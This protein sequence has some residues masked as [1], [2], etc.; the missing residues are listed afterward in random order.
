MSLDPGA[1]GRLPAAA[2]RPVPRHR[3]R[4]GRAVVL[5]LARDP[6]ATGVGVEL[7]PRLAALAAR[8]RDG[9]G[10]QPRLE[11]VVGDVRARGRLPGRRDV[12]FGRHESA[13]PDV[14]GQPP[15]TRRRTRRSRTR[16]LRSRCRSGWRARRGRCV[17]GG[18]VAAIFPAERVADLLGR[19]KP[20]ISSVPAC[21]PVHPHADAAGVAGPRRGGARRPQAAGHRTAARPSRRGRAL[22][23]GGLP[24]LPVRTKQRRCKIAAM[25]LICWRVRDW[26]ARAAAAVAAEARRARSGTAGSAW[27][28]QFQRHRRGRRAPAASSSDRRAAA[29]FTP[30]DVWNAD[31]SGRAVDAIN[32]AERMN[33]LLGSGEHP[34]RLRPRLRHPDQRGAREPGRGPDRRSTNTRTRAIR[35]HTRFPVPADPSSREPAIPTNC[36]G[37]CH[38]IVVQQGTCQVVRRLR[39]PLRAAAAGFAA[40]APTGIPPRTARA[41]VPT[42]GRPSMPPGSPSTRVSRATKRRWPAR[43]RTRCASRCRAPT[44]RASRPRPTRLSRRLPRHQPAADGPAH[45]SQGEL[46]HQRLHADGADLPARVQ[47]ARPHPRRQRREL[48]ARSTSRARTTRAGPTTSTT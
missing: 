43:S 8:G 26:A 41:S 38:V 36:D 11:I 18:R 19:C 12:R 23:A 17:P 28:G 32:T 46:R 25:R 29:L 37:D 1:A 22:H 40:T 2:A 30:D 44:T 7:Q 39:V 14:D 15:A 20:A 4:H 24:M 42:A 21:V 27:F 35:G 33:A 48:R 10:W 45:A 6:A 31:V 13:R 16:R 3:L 47:E 5:P 34:P 9:N